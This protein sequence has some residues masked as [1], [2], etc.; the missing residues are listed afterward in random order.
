MMSELRVSYTPYVF[1]DQTIPNG[2][3]LPALSCQAAWYYYVLAH[4]IWAETREGQFGL[5]EGS[6]W[7]NPEYEN[8]AHSVTTM[9][10]VTHEDMF[11]MMPFVMLEADRLGMT[12]PQQAYLKPRRLI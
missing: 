11:K 10:G 4:K 2:K 3:L 12:A 1:P 9:Y 6:P 8:L 7:L 5:L